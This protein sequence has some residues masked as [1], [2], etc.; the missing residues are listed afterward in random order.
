[1]RLNIEIDLSLPEFGIGTDDQ[2]RVDVLSEILGEF[3]EKLCWSQRS[4]KLDASFNRPLFAPNGNT[5]GSATLTP[6]PTPILRIGAT[7]HCRHEGCVGTVVV[8]DAREIVIKNTAYGYFV[9]K[10]NDIE[11]LS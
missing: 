4:V 3:A 7:V 10:H 11:V 9:V 5:I 2:T 6:S 8:F 1:M